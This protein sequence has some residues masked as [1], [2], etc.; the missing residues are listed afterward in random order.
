VS[1][2]RQAALHCSGAHECSTP[3]RQAEL[4]ICSARA[5]R[6]GKSMTI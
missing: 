1:P 2:G 5:E 4:Q 6:P 3:E